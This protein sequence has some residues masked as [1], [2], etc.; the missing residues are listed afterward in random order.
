MPVSLTPWP[1]PSPSGASGTSKYNLRPFLSSPA[2]VKRIKENGGVL[3]AIHIPGSFIPS[4]LA[5]NLSPDQLLGLKES[6]VG[7]GPET[8][9]ITGSG[10]EI[11]MSW[12][13][14][15]DIWNNNYIHGRVNTTWVKKE[16]ERQLRL[17]RGSGSGGESEMFEAESK[18]QENDE[19]S[20]DEPGSEG[21]S[22]SGGF[23]ALRNFPE[24]KAPPPFYSEADDDGII[25]DDLINNSVWM[26][27]QVGE[28]TAQ[29][30]LDV[31]PGEFLRNS[32]LERDRGV[33]CGRLPYPVSIQQYRMLPET[34]AYDSKGSST[35]YAVHT[36]RMRSLYKEESV[37]WSNKDDL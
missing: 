29:V 28:K 5:R 13:R 19:P 10:Y 34:K 18:P 15:W 12:K 7:L 4:P 16:F 24:F 1:F 32:N 8:G 21:D 36:S 22:S 27:R 6:L 2:V 33:D 11:W 17:E 23:R 9:S 35:P 14:A 37:G 31:D 30:G 26:P 25:W 3:R 20:A